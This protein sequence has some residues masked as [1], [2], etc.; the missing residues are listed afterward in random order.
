VKAGQGI[1]SLALAKILPL[2]DPIKTR[3]SEYMQYTVDN[4][5]CLIDRNRMRYLLIL[6]LLFLMSAYAEGQQ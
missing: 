5:V 4:T 2:T 1:I 6:L 3:S